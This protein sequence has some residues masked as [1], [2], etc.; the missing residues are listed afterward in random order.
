M[1]RRTPASLLLAA[2]A[3]LALTA[4]AHASANSANHRNS[5][6]GGFG[7]V[8]T[9][10]SAAASPDITPDVD[11]SPPTT[12]PSPPPSPSKSGNSKGTGSGGGSGYGNGTGDG[13]KIVSFTA[14]GA[15]CP[16]DAKPG[17]PYSQPGK[18]TISWKISSTDGV[19]L[20]MDGGLWN[21]YP[22][23]QGSDTL[24]FQCPDKTKS[25][26]HTFTLTVKGHNG[27]TRTISA[28][29]KPNP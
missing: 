19:S 6:T 22:G 4:C 25:N 8:E 10:P 9:D 2:A 16:V 21:S 5:G 7:A 13:P 29:A 28:S 23:Q 3:A 18:V 24:P 27:A 11:R 1:T 15:V 14:T 12:D 20:A 26:S 17:A